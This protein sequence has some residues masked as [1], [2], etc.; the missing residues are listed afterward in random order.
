MISAVKTTLEVPREQASQLYFILDSH[1][2]VTMHTTLAAQPGER[3]R[4]VTLLTPSGQIEEL[5]VIL[6][7]LESIGVRVLKEER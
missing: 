5:R 4:T 1:E 7:Q 6:K 3:L 2:G